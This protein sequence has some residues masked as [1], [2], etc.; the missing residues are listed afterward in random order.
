MTFGRFELLASVVFF[1]LFLWRS[2]AQPDYFF[3]TTALFTLGLVFSLVSVSW[4][5]LA[6]VP[7]S[8][9]DG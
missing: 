5:F 4:P 2:T 1:Y 9:P 3:S 6:L 7:W 8:R